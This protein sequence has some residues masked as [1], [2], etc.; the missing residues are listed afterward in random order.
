[1]TFLIPSQARQSNLETLTM[2]H[3]TADALKTTRYQFRGYPNSYKT[4]S[5]T[6]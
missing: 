6:R 5:S 2:I 4:F 3:G 1:M